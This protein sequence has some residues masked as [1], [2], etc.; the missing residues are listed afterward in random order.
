MMPLA[1]RADER[2][3]HEH[4]TPERTCV[5][6]RRKGD[7]DGADPARARPRRPGR[8]RRPRRR[9]GRG[10]WIRRPRRAR[11]AN[12][13]GKLKGALARAFKTKARLEIPADLGERIEQALRQAALDRL[14][15]E[16]RSAT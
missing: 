1:A 7:K 11:A 14:G 15:M 12:A 16:A 10:A 4:D 3:A 8:A 5:L 6:T 9:P 2:E 13:K